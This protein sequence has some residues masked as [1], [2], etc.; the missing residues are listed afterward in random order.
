MSNT[1]ATPRLPAPPPSC[2]SPPRV[3]EKIV[4][5]A[6]EEDNPRG[7]LTG[8]TLIP[9]HAH[10][11]AAVIAREPGIC[12]GL[13]TF[14]AAMKLSDPA[15]ERTCALADGDAFA[16]GDTLVTV[17]GP[18]RGL[19]AGERVGLNLLQRLSG[20]ATATAAFVAGGRREPAPGSWTP[21]RPRRGC[22]C[23]NATR[24]A[25]AAGTTTATTSP[26]R[27][28]P[29]TTTWPCWAPAPS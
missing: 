14:I 28:W 2:R 10:A 15:L 17:T 9:A 12:A 24:C 4:L 21:A 13:E 3:I 25:A 5:A 29:R 22:A 18:A 19:L 7:D 16:A 20:I 8:N 1:T 27:S 26:R 11:T 23:W 6:L